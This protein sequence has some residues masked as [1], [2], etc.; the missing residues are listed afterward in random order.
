MERSGLCYE[1]G[2]PHFIEKVTEIVVIT[3]PIVNVQFAAQQVWFSL[4]AFDFLNER[5]EFSPYRER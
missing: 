3:V 1:K 5:A 2:T 4:N